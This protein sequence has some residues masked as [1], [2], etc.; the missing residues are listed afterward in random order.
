MIFNIAIIVLGIIQII[1]IIK[2][3]E[4][5]EDIKSI[6]RGFDTLTKRK[7]MNTPNISSTPEIQKESISEKKDIENSAKFT[8]QSWVAIIII[9]IAAICYFILS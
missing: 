2:F 6:R 8:W 1:M 3:F 4:I 5:A 9:V 7:G